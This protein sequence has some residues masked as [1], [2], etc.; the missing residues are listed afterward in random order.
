MRYVTYYYSFPGRLK[1]I[2]LHDSKEDAVKF[3]RKEAKHYFDV[4]LPRKTETPTS[5]GFTH[6]R[7]G[8]MSVRLFRKNFPAWKGCVS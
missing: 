8:V 7:F 5:C 1:D 3:Y 2:V 4:R 6:R